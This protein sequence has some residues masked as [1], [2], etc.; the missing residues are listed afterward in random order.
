MFIYA[1]CPIDMFTSEATHVTF[2]APYDGSQVCPE[3]GA[4]GRGVRLQRPG[5][6]FRVLVMIGCG[7]QS[8]HSAPYVIGVTVLTVIDPTLNK[9]L[10]MVGDNER[11]CQVHFRCSLRYS[12]FP[13]NEGKVQ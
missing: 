4:R 2:L 7:S 3:E 6:W 13:T 10:I 9:V 8:K 5:A 12:L 1:I 11:Y